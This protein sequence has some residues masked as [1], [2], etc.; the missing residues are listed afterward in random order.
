MNPLFDGLKAAAEASIFGESIVC[1]GLT[2]GNDRL[3]GQER[4]AL[5]AQHDSLHR[6]PH[7][8]TRK[9]LALLDSLGRE[10]P[11]TGVGRAIL[12][13][14]GVGNQVEVHRFFF[15]NCLQWPTRRAG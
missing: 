5:G 7:L 13:G 11:S 9:R 14:M 15:G 2:L 3:N 1:S 8:Q 6:V 10:S 12:N 4:L